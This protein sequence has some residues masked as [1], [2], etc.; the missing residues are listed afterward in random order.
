[1]PHVAHQEQALDPSPGLASCVLVTQSLSAWHTQDTGGQ[2]SSTSPLCPQHGACDV[3]R[4]PK[5]T[6][7]CPGLPFPPHPLLQAARKWPWCL[8]A[9]HVEKSRVFPGNQFINFPENSLSCAGIGDSEG[10]KSRCPELGARGPGWPQPIRWGTGPTSVF[11]EMTA[12]VG[13]S[14][15]LFLC[16]KM[17]QKSMT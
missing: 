17:P 1:M 7:S 11:C 13:Y 9:K 5:A 6:P 4:G 12:G 10:S 8:G 14:G 3:A 15:K 2:G 16:H